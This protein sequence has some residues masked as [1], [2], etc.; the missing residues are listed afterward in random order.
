MRHWLA[1][2]FAIASALFCFACAQAAS[3]DLGRWFTA[4]SAWDAS[5]SGTNLSKPDFLAGTTMQSMRCAARGIAIGNGIWS[6]LKYD[7]KH[8]I[9]LA[10]AS[11][12]QCSVSVFK[13]LPPGV[14]VPDADLTRY[15]TGRGVRIGSSYAD[16]LAAYGGARKHGRHFVA[17]YTANVADRTLSGKPIS[18][19]EEI[20]FVIQD[21]RVAAITVSIDMSGQF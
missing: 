17:F 18:D 2:A 21:G 11:T 16:V 7:R 5:G 20:S 15:G 12:D 6:L 9:G 10:A 13:A 19:S 1:C 8:Q 3:A 4:A 14:T